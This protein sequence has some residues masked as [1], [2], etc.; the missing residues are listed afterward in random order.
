MLNLKPEVLKNLYLKKEMTPYEIAKALKCNHK[1]VR[2]YLKKYKIPLRIASEYNFLAKQ[3]YIKPPKEK[4]MEAK[5]IAA[6]VA[7][8]CEGWHT[9]KS[10]HVSFCNQD[11]QLIDLI[12]WMLKEVYKVKTLQVVISYSEGS[13]ISS[14]TEIY[15]EARL[16]I[17]GTR[18]NPIVRVRSGGKMLVRDLVQNCYM[19]LNSLS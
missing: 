9:E 14:L 1:T 16:S 6:H 4:L 19:I 18:K 17:D 5:S 3:N 7:Y 11:T 15:P 8:L 10:N 2:S 12:I 13:D